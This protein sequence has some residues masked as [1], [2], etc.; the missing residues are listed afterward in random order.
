MFV[1]RLEGALPFMRF[2]S[3]FSLYNFFFSFI[4]CFLSIK[5][6]RP[7]WGREIIHDYVLYT[8][9]L[10]STTL[11]P[12]ATD[13][14]WLYV[15]FGEFINFALRS[16]SSRGTPLFGLNVYVPLNRV[17]FWGSW[18]LRVCNLRSLFSAFNRQVSIS[19]E[20]LE[21]NCTVMQCL[22]RVLAVGCLHF[23]GATF[24]KK[25]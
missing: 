16:L 6:L 1:N 3:A 4:F 15:Y 5:C 11:N 18:V 14:V 17:W 13:T 23:Y 19:N 20:S 8:D 7:T 10:V 25:M 21:R 12:S 24:F 9:M 2:K 22:R